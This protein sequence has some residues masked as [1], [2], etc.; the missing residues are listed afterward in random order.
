MEEANAVQKRQR[1]EAEN[2]DIPQH[3]WQN[4]LCTDETKMDLFG[5]NTQR[6]VCGG[7]KKCHS[8]PTSKPHPHCELWWNGL[9]SWTKN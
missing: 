6:F 7:V 2:L 9:L 3:S 4:I 5:R 8:T 1:P